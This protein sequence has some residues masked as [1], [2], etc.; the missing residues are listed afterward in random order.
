M[1]RREPGGMARVPPGPSRASQGRPQGFDSA[2]RAAGGEVDGH[3]T[4]GSSVM[5]RERHGNGY[6][7]RAAT[8]RKMHANFRGFADHSP[9]SLKPAH[10][11]V[12]RV[13]GFGNS[14]VR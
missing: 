10:G 7:G 12:G 3:P 13:V 4:E 5:A 2:P 8:R 1:A 11:R 9:R 6:K 14:L